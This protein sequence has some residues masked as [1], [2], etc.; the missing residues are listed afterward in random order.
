MVS[1]L[2]ESRGVTATSK[3][4]DVMLG[5]RILVLLTLHPMLNALFCFLQLNNERGADAT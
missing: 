2:I 1:A 3:V 5:L 4:V